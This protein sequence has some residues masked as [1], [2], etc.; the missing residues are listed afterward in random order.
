M[1]LININ[2][3]VSAFH[4]LSVQN[5]CGSCLPCG[6]ILRLL[7]DSTQACQGWNINY[8]STWFRKTS[9]TMDKIS[10]NDLFATE[11]GRKQSDEPLPVFT[12]RA[13]GVT[14]CL[15]NSPHCSAL[16]R[17]IRWRLENQLWFLRRIKSPEQDMRLE[18]EKSGL[19][20]SPLCWNILIVTF[21][22][23]SNFLD[24][25]FTKVSCHAHDLVYCSSWFWTRLYI[26]GAGVT[27]KHAGSRLHPCKRE[28]MKKQC[29]HGSGTAVVAVES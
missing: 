17:Q 10:I 22:L 1:I 23:P 9:W 20:A 19:V 18:V 12:S 25:G 24:Y 26:Y 6:T 16:W 28:W 7:S 27:R 11:R 14:C 15:T 13:T 4:Q 21:K 2:S 3:L 29:R 8:W 5:W